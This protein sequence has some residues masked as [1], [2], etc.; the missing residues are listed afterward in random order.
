LG[1]RDGLHAPCNKVKMNDLLLRF[2]DELME[3]LLLKLTLLFKTNL[4]LQHQ[5]E[6]SQPVLVLKWVAV[7]GIQDNLLASN[8]W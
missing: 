3:I 8:L 4:L 5:S 7:F 1:I 6:S 2:H